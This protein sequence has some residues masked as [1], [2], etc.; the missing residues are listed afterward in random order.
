M[1][2]KGVRLGITGLVL[3]LAF[4]GLLYSTMS[5]GMEY[6]KHVEEVMANPQP[7]HGKKLQLHGFASDV[8]R[9]RNTLDYRFVVESGGHKVNATYSGL[10][11][12]TFKNGAEVV[13]KGTLGPEGFHVV[14][15]GIMAKCP[16][17][18]EPGAAGA[19]QS[20]GTE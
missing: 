15:D 10:V 12:D 7:W 13:L 11:P 3:T 14:E 4:G 5:E 16:S 20:P 18:Y 9:S 2:K 6:Y 1:S 8:L 19:P 17:K